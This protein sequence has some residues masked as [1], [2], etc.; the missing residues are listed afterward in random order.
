[1]A[2]RANT[3]YF[4]KNNLD[5]FFVEN[6]ILYKIG[7][8]II[9]TKI[10]RD[11]DIYKKNFFFLKFQTIHEFLKQNVFTNFFLFDTPI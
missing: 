3:A 8:L 9:F 1:M 2:Y 11:Q 5:N 10:I 6:L 7:V 4:R